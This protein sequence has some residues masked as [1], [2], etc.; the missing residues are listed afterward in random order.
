MSEMLLDNYSTVFSHPLYVAAREAI[1]ILKERYPE[2]HFDIGGYDE[3]HKPTLC[4]YEIRPDKRCKSGKRYV[5][6]HWFRPNSN[7][8][9]HVDNATHLLKELK[10][11]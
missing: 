10:F 3:T 7:T 6:T 4:F 9:T 11:I 1:S 2:H 8:T 5:K